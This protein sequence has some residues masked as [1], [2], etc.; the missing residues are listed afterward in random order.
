[1]NLQQITAGAVSAVNPM[2]PCS[3]QI[4]TGSTK[5]ADFTRV[6]TYATP[7]IM[8]GQIQSLTF[9]DIMQIEGL[10]LNGTRKAIYLTGKVDALVREENK[11]G[12][13]ITFPDGTVWL[14]AIVLEGW[15]QHT[16]SA[17]PGWVKVAVTQQLS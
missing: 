13:L 8:Q 9:R 3:V 14:V 2:V 5:E 1:M 16:G 11:G 6:P 17:D 7:V 12:D 10:N 4:S 15:L